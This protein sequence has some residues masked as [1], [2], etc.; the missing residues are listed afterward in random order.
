MYILKRSGYIMKDRRVNIWK[1]VI[2]SACVAAA[3]A[4][5]AITGYK[6]FKKYFKITF[7]CGED[8]DSCIDG[9]FCDEYDDD[10]FIPEC[11]YDDDGIEVAFADAE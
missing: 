7:D 1:V 9:C 5:I 3:V 2:I 10:D 11:S 4:A 8:C 6:L